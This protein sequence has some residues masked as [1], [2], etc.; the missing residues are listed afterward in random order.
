MVE[1]MRYRRY[2]QAHVTAID[3]GLTPHYNTHQQSNLRWS[4]SGTQIAKNIGSYLIPL[5]EELLELAAGT[6]AVDSL[7]GVLFS[8]RAHLL[9]GFG[10]IPA[11]S[12]LLE[13][14]GHNGRYPCRF[15]L[16]LAI[17]GITVKG[18]THLYCPLHRSH[19]PSVDSFNLP[20]R[21]HQESLRDGLDVLRAPT[22]HARSQLATR[23]GIKGV[24]VLARVPSVCIPHSFLVNIMHMG[25]INL[26]PQLTLLWTG[27]F[28]KLY[29]GRER[30]SIHPTVWEALGHVTEASGNTIPSS[31]G[32]RVPNLKSQSSHF[33]AEAWSVWATQLAPSLLR[34]RFRSSTYYIHF[35]QLVQLMNRCLSF[36][37]RRDEIPE[38]RDG[39]IAWVREYER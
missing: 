36:T 10:D 31:F 4:H 27:E 17:Q 6:P 13:F 32:C 3:P 22:D 21:T 20:L 19:G 12:K 30:Y 7:K 9:V 23:T 14:V 25:W 26:I 37:M 35:V 11:L 8:L 15:C 29:Q 38:I 33:T 39:F 28:H 16:I 18:G 34:R 24:S 1:E 2:V 5:I